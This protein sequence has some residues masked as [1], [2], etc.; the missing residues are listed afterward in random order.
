MPILGAMSFSAQSYGFNSLPLTVGGTY[1]LANQTLSGVNLGAS[2]ITVDSAGNVLTNGTSY[3]GGRGIGNVSKFS[4]TGTLTW[5]KSDYVGTLGSTYDYGAGIV[6]DAS[7]NVI[8]NTPYDYSVQKP[9]LVKLDSSGAKVWDRG[10][11]WS[12]GGNTYGYGL[13]K[14]S[15]D[16]F[17]IPGI[18]YYNG[19]FSGFVAKYNSAG[20][21][22]WERKTN[23][24]ADFRLMDVACDSSGNVFVAGYST[25]SGSWQG[26][27]AKYNSSGTVQWQKS[28]SDS[29]VT[30]SNA[31]AVDSSGNIYFVTYGGSAGSYV[32]HLIKLDTSGSLLWQRKFSSNSI[33]IDVAVDSSGNAY[34]IGTTG[35]TGFIVKYNSSGTLQW[36]RT[37]TNIS[38]GRGIWAANSAVYINCEGTVGSNTAIVTGKFPDNGSKTGTYTVGGQT[39]T[40]AAGAATEGAGS[41]TVGAL[42]NSDAAGSLTG[43]TPGV[44]VANTNVTTNSSII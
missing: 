26:W 19:T 6:V 43:V 37:L 15:S 25:L 14:D 16:N 5:S 20:T 21:L 13:G 3:S 40:Y 28:L 38:A 39:Y 17:F 22:Q 44:T 27:I 12:G 35:S 7:N 23:S 2:T 41:L 31:A 9:S 32:A 33:L 29:V 30:Y 10:L 8:V 18:S 4:S 24:S 36:Q 11:S 1:F 42:T 34:A